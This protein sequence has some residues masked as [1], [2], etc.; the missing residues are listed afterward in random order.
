M[1]MSL[2]VVVS[3]SLAAAACT[4]MSSNVQTTASAGG[5]GDPVHA[6]VIL[7]APTTFEV[8][9]ANEERPR[10]QRELE[11]GSLKVVRLVVHDLRARSAEG[12][13]GVRVF[14]GRPDAGERTPSDDPHEA[15]AFVL[16]LQSPETLLFNVAPTLSRLWQSGELKAADLAANKPL[17][18]TFVPEPADAATRLRKD[19]ALTFDRVTFEV[20]EQP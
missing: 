6:G 7:A 1:A 20:P 8:A 10:M 19:F 5:K 18:V 2:V 12:L 13:K 3:L 14:I 11:R 17:R 15:A 9:I 4:D 16:G